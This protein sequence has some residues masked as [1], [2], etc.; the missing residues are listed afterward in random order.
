M[1]G[2]C[3]RHFSEKVKK[4]GWRGQLLHLLSRSR[5]SLRKSPP[6]TPPSVDEESSG[7]DRR[8]ERKLTQVCST[9]APFSLVNGGTSCKPQPQCSISAPMSPRTRSWW[10]V[11]KEAS[12]CVRSL[13]S[14]LRCWPCSRVCLRA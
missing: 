13:I 12:P 5:E 10:R 9:P 1:V 2:W 7:Y 3:F 4:P 14:A 8:F 11:R 6:P